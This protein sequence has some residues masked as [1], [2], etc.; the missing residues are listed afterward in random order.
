[1][2]DEAEGQRNSCRLRR[3]EVSFPLPH[4]TA[5]CSS[6]VS[7]RAY[8]APCLKIVVSVGL[9]AVLFSRVDGRAPVDGR[10]SGVV[11]W[12][13][14]RS[15]LYALMVAANT[16]RWRVLLKAQNVR[17]SSAPD[18]IISVATFFNNFLP[19]NIGGCGARH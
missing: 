19:S 6:C 5:T 18:L 11:R 13:L 17:L 1:M 4:G 3:L 14:A 7:L 9:L 2:A 12:L 15:P 16:W 10:P 8:L